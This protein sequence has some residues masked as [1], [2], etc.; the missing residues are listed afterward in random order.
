MEKV[1]AVLHE[2]DLFEEQV[3]LFS[4]QAFLSKKVLGGLLQL[5]VGALNLLDVDLLL[6]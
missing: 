3:G 2:I 1:L 6:L 4:A 5:V